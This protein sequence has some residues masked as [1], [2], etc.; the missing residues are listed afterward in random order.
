MLFAARFILAAILIP[1]W[2]AAGASEA[3]IPGL[4]PGVEQAPLEPPPYLAQCSKKFGP[5]SPGWIR[6]NYSTHFICKNG[7][8]T[9]GDPTEIRSDR[10]D[11]QLRLQGGRFKVRKKIFFVYKGSVRNYA[12]VMGRLKMLKV[13]AEQ[14]YSRNGLDLQLEFKVDS[15]AQKP[16]QS[17]ARVELWDTV[18][19]SR[20]DRWALLNEY[21]QALDG[22]ENCALAAHEIGHSLG[23][24]DRYSDPDCPDRDTTAPTGDI[25]RDAKFAAMA[26]ETIHPDDLK[27]IVTPLCGG[28]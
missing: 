18:D 9:A 6:I 4:P 3:A 20:S 5:D 8:G 16:G 10:V 11:Y 12:T 17:G 26:K 19:R 22:E 1:A 7:S 23:L 15:K 13:C 25:M 21:G 2:P 27:T 14:F 24:P 28:K